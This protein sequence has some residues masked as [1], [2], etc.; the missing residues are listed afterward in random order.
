MEER[1]SDTS[2]ENIDYAGLC[3]NSPGIDQLKPSPRS[4]FGPLG[5][6]G[7]SGSIGYGAKSILGSDWNKSRYDND[8]MLGLGIA[9]RA[10]VRSG[11]VT[12]KQCV[13]IYYRYDGIYI[14]LSLK[15]YT[16]VS[17]LMYI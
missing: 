5:T 2:D 8:N 6:M 17:D 4:P 15:F 11:S 16:N 12:A 1:S 10:R 9:S 14:C 3:V 13:R 7:G